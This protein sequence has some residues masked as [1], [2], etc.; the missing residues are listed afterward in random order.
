MGLCRTGE[1]SPVTL[2]NTITAGGGFA[3]MWVSR[4][5]QGCRAVSSQQ[6]LGKE[7]AGKPSDGLYQGH[8]SQPGTRES[9]PLLSAAGNQFVPGT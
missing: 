3:N 9:F 8:P 6:E 7:K 1:H 4:S 5:E 2:Q